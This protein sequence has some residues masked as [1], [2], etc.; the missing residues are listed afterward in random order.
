M[1]HLILAAAICL[2]AG[3]ASAQDV[4]TPGKGSPER[5]AILDTLRVPVKKQ[6]KQD[7]VFAVN[8]FRVTGNWAFVGGE[9]QVAGGGQ[10]DYSGTAYQEAKE[11][12]MFDN[13]FFALLKRTN[14]KWRVVTFAIGC[15]DVCYADWWRRYKAPKA[16]FPYSE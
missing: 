9:P 14:G 7:I 2:T 15:T 11:A 8:D 1:R 5:K 6:L 3:F 4:H 16:V 12:G 13:N 10:P